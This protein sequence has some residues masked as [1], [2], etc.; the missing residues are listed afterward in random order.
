MNTT[1]DSFPQIAPLVQDSQLAGTRMTCVFACPVSGKTARGAAD[2]VKANGLGTKVKST[3]RS[4]VIRSASRSIGSSLRSVLGNG[5]V[6]RLAGEVVRDKA[7]EAQ[8]DGGFD[9]AELQSATMAAFE[10]VRAQFAWDD[11][12]QRFVHASALS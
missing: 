9:E 5:V 7:K 6:G 1:P 4:S 11:G 10:Q 8:A 3:L 12:E 2:V